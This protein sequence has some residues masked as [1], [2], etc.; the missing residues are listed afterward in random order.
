LN[1]KFKVLY[2][3]GSPSYELKQDFPT[4]KMN[5]KIK[6]SS[7]GKS[8]KG[9]F[10]AFLLF[11]F[12]LLSLTLLSKSILAENTYMT[13]QLKKYGIGCTP[14]P[15][16]ALGP[17][18]KPNAPV[19]ASVG[20]GYELKGMVM[21]SK[22]CSPIPGARI[23]LWMAGP[24]GEYKDNFRATVISNESGEYRFESHGPPSYLSRPPHIHMRVSATGFK[25]LITQHYPKS[26]TKSAELELVLIP[27]K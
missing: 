1:K 17:F 24:D 13:A 6:I 21:S 20:K 9:N 23:E 19:R 16:D 22:D 14:T 18:Y 3:K 26:R 27:D 12:V 7:E 11:S 8:V 2:Y 4:M 15:P 10:L 5:I 25:T